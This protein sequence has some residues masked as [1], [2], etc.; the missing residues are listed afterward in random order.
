MSQFLQH[1][2]FAL[3]VRP[4]IMVVLG[5]NVRNRER[6]P[7]TGPAIIV[8]NHNSHLDTMVLMSLFPQSVL[9]KLRPVA[10]M[11]YFMKNRLLSWFSTKIIGIIPLSRKR[12]KAKETLDDRL[13]GLYAGL[14]RGDIVILFP[15][16]SRGDPE[17]MT[18]FKSGIAH[19]AQKNPD[20][21]VYPLF[22][23]GLGK[24][25][26]KGEMIPVPFFCD[27]WVGEPMTWNGE[28]DNFMDELVGR[29]DH[30]SEAGYQPD[31]S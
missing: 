1:A 31:W 7:R 29:V 28:E 5:V 27:V 10:A 14:A 13:A 18:E 20:V 19:I 22:L 2:F 4:F 11:D 23:H 15:E 3:I 21:P 8:A 9:P 16:G 6:L 24:V 30:L 17:K 26:P 12:G 25:L